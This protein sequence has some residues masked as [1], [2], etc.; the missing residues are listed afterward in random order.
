MRRF[1]SIVVWGL[2]IMEFAAVGA[3]WRVA[4]AGG[5]YLKLENY[6]SSEEAQVRRN[7]EKF[8]AEFAYE[9]AQIT[10]RVVS[11]KATTA[12][13]FQV[14]F[15]Y[16]TAQVT[17]KI[18]AI[19]P[20]KQRGEFAY[21]MAQVTGK[22]LNNPNVNIEKAKADFSYDIA[23]LTGKILASLEKGAQGIKKGGAGGEAASGEVGS[24]VAA[25]A[26]NVEETP[27]PYRPDKETVA[28]RDSSYY[29]GGPVTKAAEPATA[30]SERLNNT[31]KSG[32]TTEVTKKKQLAAPANAPVVTNTPVAANAG[33]G[34]A[35][36]RSNSEVVARRNP[37]DVPKDSYNKMITDIIDVGKRGAKVDNSVKVSGEVRAH[38]AGNSGDAPYDKSTSGLRTRI[39]LES[40]VNKNWTA[41]GMVEAT[42]GFKNYQSQTSF[43]RLYG[44]GKYDDYTITAGSFGYLMADGN[45]YDS[46][47]KGARFDFGSAPM[48]YTLSKGETD[49]TKNN[50]IAGVRYGSFDYDLEAGMYNYASKEDGQKNTIT[51]A[52]GN[53]K[54]EDVTVGAMALK[55]TRKGS[56]GG[57]T[58]Y[59]LSSSIGDLKTYRRGTYTVFAKYYDQPEYTYIS[60]GM[61][62]LGGSMKGFTGYGVGMSYTFAPNLVGG[63][64]YYDLEDKFTG[65]KG[66][67]W[68]NHVTCYF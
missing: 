34:K 1:L 59:V 12:E 64:E 49:Y 37:G 19:I 32:E 14:E 24:R 54:F 20:D 35:G 13:A 56:D 26:A 17:S 66:N 57:T 16:A 65:K 39:G 47:F 36:L 23:V 48:Q 8:K 18:L 60:H 62:G 63:I 50:T 43:N 28:P 38:Y 7:N 44:V 2:A 15:S 40:K 10:T 53:Y 30:G 61:N 31:A 9:M 5:K 52:G 4:H 29:A 3:D 25:K 58:G 68:W 6:D 51:T 22:V 45:I 42:T 11:G 55:S 27:V 67:T 33:Y 21:E 41:H 46:R